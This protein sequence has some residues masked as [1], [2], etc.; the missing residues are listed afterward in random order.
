MFAG[1]ANGLMLELIGKL[2]TDEIGGR[3]LEFC[4]SVLKFLQQGVEGG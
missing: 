2:F 4:G 3:G 1:R